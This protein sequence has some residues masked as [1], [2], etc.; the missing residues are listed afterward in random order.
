MPRLN[1]GKGK[2]KAAR[3]KATKKPPS[4]KKKNAAKPK[5]ANKGKKDAKKKKENTEE[6]AITKVSPGGAL[7]APDF[8][9]GGEE[10]SKRGKEN[11][12]PEDLGTPRVALLQALSPEVTG[13]AGD[14]YGPD[15][16]YTAGLYYYPIAGHLFGEGFHF[17]I[18]AYQKDYIWWKPRSEGGGIIAR[19]TPAQVAAGEYPEGTSEDDLKFL[20]NEPPR[21]TTHMNFLVLEYDPD[22]DVVDPNKLGPFIFSCQKTTMA[23]G[24][25]LC[26]WMQASDKAAYVRVYT[27]QSKRVS[28]A[29]GTFYVHDVSPEFNYD[30]EED[31][32]EG[33]VP[34]W[35]RS[36]ESYKEIEAWYEKFAGKEVK[37]RYD[38]EDDEEHA[39]TAEGDAGDD[40][41]GDD[42]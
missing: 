30:S 3:T 7:A 38:R 27:T 33:V 16:G 11:I 10:Y 14:A 31:V 37:T 5:P 36:E 39:D 12:T 26:R 4:K 32:P 2:G 35:P 18:L 42:F 34:G 23:A 20:N 6:K 9:P 13:E 40:V 25:A 17:V 8:I 22:E 21:A 1:K 41:G 19:M 28:N 24:K 15:N 29:K